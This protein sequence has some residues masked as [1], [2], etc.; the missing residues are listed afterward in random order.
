M[1][2]EE[3]KNGMNTG[4]TE[5]MVTNPAEIAKNL[6]AAND[7]VAA[8]AEPDDADRTELTAEELAEV[9]ALVPTINVADETYVSKYGSNAMEEV[10]IAGTAAVKGAKIGDIEGAS[11]IITGMESQLRDFRAFVIARKA[12]DNIKRELKL[13]YKKFEPVEHYVN[14]IEKDLDRYILTFDKDIALDE[15]RYKANRVTS[16]KLLV[17]IRAGRIALKNAREVTLVELRN[18]AAQTQ[19][20]DDQQEVSRFEKRCNDFE[21]QLVELEKSRTLAFLRG[22][23][24]EMQKEAKRTVGRSLENMKNH[25]VPTL[26]DAMAAALGMTHLKKGI[27]LAET[28]RKATDDMIKLVADM[29]GQGALAAEKARGEG[30][31]GMEAIIYAVDKYLEDSAAIKAVVQENLTNAR[32]TVL[33]LEKLEN[34]IVVAD[35]Q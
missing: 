20:R 18:K 3:I 22:P 14:T 5:T 31:A 29:T 11:K 1:S 34:K 13:L 30:F 27:Q 2:N 10:R 7:M 28:T 21:L 17:C 35:K 4:G 19:T 15:E 23:Q 25:A 16:R 9:K 32:N 12:Y 24:I 8:A 33:E 6:N 26:F